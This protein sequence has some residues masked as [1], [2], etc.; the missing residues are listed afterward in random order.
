MKNKEDYQGYKLSCTEF[1]KNHTNYHIHPL[2]I[3]HVTMLSI[4]GRE[5]LP[6]FIEF[7]NL[8]YK[9][10]IKLTTCDTFFQSYVL[11]NNAI[12]NN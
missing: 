7:I 2:T 9:V 12:K 10:N 8:K 1:I 5:H 4:F 11:L 6:R 3:D